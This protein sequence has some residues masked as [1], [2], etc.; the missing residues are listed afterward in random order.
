MASAVAPL[1]AGLPQRGVPPTLG[2]P[3]GSRASSR[4]SKPVSSVQGGVPG[5]AVSRVAAA[6]EGCA[7]QANRINPGGAEIPLTRF[8]GLPFS[9]CMF[10]HMGDRKTQEDRYLLVPKVDNDRNMGPSSF[11]GVFDGTVGDFA[12]ENVKDLVVP[13][14][15]ESATWKAL[16]SV[17]S[18]RAAE[19]ERM[20]QDTMRDLYR[21]V[22][23][24]LLARCAQNTQH[25]ATCT[26]VT[27]L[28][29]QDL[30][31]VSHLGDSRIV[32]GREAEGSSPAG[33]SR[34]SRAIVGE[35]LTV[36]HKPD[37]AAERAR[38]EQCGGMVERLQSH[39]NKPFIRGG[40][41]LMRKALGEQPMQL[42]YSRAFGAKDLK[43]FGLSN[44]PDVK[45]IR[46]GTSPYRNCR[47]AVLA[48]DGLWDV[49]SAQQAVEVVMAAAQ[50]ADPNPAEEL[51]RLALT[52]QSRRK[53]RA[54]NV[55]AVCILFDPC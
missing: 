32:L 27:M 4:P 15:L 3:G 33:G 24:A 8:N 16:K 21:S 42:Q 23:D 47:V 28:L 17:P 34:G 54:D 26:S 55:T 25:Y 13:K 46:M 52:E 20:L 19:R 29:T 38:I 41:F 48:S 43:C 36:D 5:A 49:I 12:S 22:D 2:T 44:V 39:C 1:G 37:L 18:T 51:V 50:R 11:F 40:D 30:L 7:L 45:I 35:Q 14:L 10:Q 6:E 53:S 31:V 9:V